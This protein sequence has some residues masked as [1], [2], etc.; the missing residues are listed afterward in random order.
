MK[1]FPAIDLYGGKV[2]RLTQG[3]YGR[4]RQYGVTP[5][6]AAQAYKD[7]GCENIHIV[8]LEGAEKGVPCHLDALS[9]IAALGMF[10]QYGGGLRTADAVASA[11]ESGAARVMAGSLIFRHIEAAGSLAERFGEK[12]MAAADIKN[13]K[14]VHSG[15]LQAS[16]IGP[17]EA[18]AKLAGL[19]FTSFLVTLTEKDGM[20][21]GTDPEFYKTLV[22]P[23]ITIAAAGGITSEKDIAALAAAGVNAAVIGKSLYEGGITIEGA[24]KAAGERNK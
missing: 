17:A 15:W 5:L 23:G 1:I 19:G 2:V 18:V 9:G 8:D 13:G 3:D 21:Q 12:I 10:T 16:D 20:M 22:R 4:K 7:A 11:I 24:L 14:V 6:E